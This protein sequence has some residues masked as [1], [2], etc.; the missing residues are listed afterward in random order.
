MS[1][2]FACTLPAERFEMMDALILEEDRL[3]F[4]HRACRSVV[5]CECL[6]G[7]PF[8][9]VPQAGNFIGSAEGPLFFMAAFRRAVQKW[10]DATEDFFFPIVLVDACA[11]LDVLRG[12]SS[13]MDAGVIPFF[14]PLRREGTERYF[15]VCGRHFCDSCGARRGPFRCSPPYFARRSAFQ[16]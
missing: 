10:L 11:P 15:D 9:M 13:L 3:L 7:P 12:D 5:Q 16:P 4:D 1:N 2:A 6:D 8:W 14:F